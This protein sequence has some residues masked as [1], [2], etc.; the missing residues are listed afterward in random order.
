MKFNQEAVRAARI[1]KNGNTALHLAAEGGHVKV[2][3]LLLN[4][5]AKA[6]DENLDGMTPLSLASQEGHIRVIQALKGALDW[7]ACSKK[8]GLSA[9]HVAA[10]SGKV[11]C[12]SELLTEIPAGIKSERSLADPNADYGITPL[13]LASENG[14]EG[15]VRLLMNSPGVQVDEQTTVNETIPMHLGKSLGISQPCIRANHF[16]P[17][18]SRPRRSH[19]CGRSVNLTVGRFVA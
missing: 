1:K 13:H 15:V 7:K 8:N 14:H 10:R 4:A 19:A 18:C 9:L 16:P 17:S 11:E 3:K 12:V 6:N 2:V 5:G